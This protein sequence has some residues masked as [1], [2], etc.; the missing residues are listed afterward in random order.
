MTEILAGSEHRH[1]T[2]ALRCC[3]HTWLLCAQTQ[4]SLD[5]RSLHAQ[6]MMQHF[7]L[8]YCRGCSL[9]HISSTQQWKAS[10]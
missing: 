10:L 8:S 9:L 7:P 5:G 2:V 6:G 3:C 1:G 4:Q